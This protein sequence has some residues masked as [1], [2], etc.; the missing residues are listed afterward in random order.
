MSITVVTFSDKG[1]SVFISNQSEHQMFVG[2]FIKQRIL[3][4]FQKP[5]YRLNG[6]SCRCLHQRIVAESTINALV[7]DQVYYIR[8]PQA[9]AL[10]EIFA[11][12]STFKEFH[13]AAAVSDKF[14][15]H[16]ETANDCDA[17]GNFRSAKTLSF[18]N[19][20]N[21]LLGFTQDPLEE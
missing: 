16:L 14:W 3:S 7:T 20:I 12:E 21:D 2:N 10:R 6:I 8:P 17:S 19:F 15:S 18:H 11:P 5:N 13:V 9:S 4:Y 1:D